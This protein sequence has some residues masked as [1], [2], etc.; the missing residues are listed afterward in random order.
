MKENPFKFGAIVENEF[1][2]DRN[3]ERRQLR[4]ALNS[5]NH[6]ILI[7]PRRYGKSSLVANVLAELSRPS[8]TVNM[9]SVT[10]VVDLAM[11]LLRRAFTRFPI[12]RVKYLLRHFRFVPT[13]SVNPLTNGLDLAFQPDVNDSV[14]LEDVLSLIDRLGEKQRV[15]VVMDEFQEIL[16]LEK[17]LDKKLRAYMQ[18]HQHINYVLLGSQESM[19]TAIFDHKTSPFYH[20]GMLMHISRIP[21]DEFKS[22]LSQRFSELVDDPEPLSEAVLA[23]TDCHPYYTQQLAYQVWNVLL[24]GGDATLSVSIAMDEIVQLHDYDYERMWMSMNKTDKATL[25]RLATSTHTT[26]R[27]Q[28]NPPSTVFSSLKKLVGKGFVLKDDKYRIDDPFF[29]LWIK[30]NTL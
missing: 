19:M 18:T 5:H 15:V 13:L 26:I 3:V 1:F 23:F 30:R 7:S 17:G 29:E 2:T 21:H 10:S 25:M 4:D 14:V 6:I 12:E 20:F 16:N 24:R 8:L 28:A 9:Q 22:F 11:H 27:S